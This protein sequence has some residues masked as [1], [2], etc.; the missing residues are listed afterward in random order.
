MGVKMTLTAA[1]LS[2]AG[3]DVSGSSKKVE[4]TV[5]VDEKDVTTFA[6]LGW[7]EVQGGLKSGTL[8]AD[9]FNDVTAGALDDDMWAALGNV[10]PFE[11]RLVNSP[12]SASNPKYT[13]SVLVKDWTPI[14]G[15]PGDT[16]EV[17]ISYPT[18]G[19]V[20]RATA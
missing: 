16:A 4:L 17:S 13:G 3:N 9:L 19:A 6:S 18:S 11:V 5:T 8:A 14:S 15:A 1:F 20:V 12:A 2:L 7:K 10:V